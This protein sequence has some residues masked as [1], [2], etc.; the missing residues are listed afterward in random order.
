MIERSS[1]H[2]IVPAP[3]LPELLP[4]NK[5]W[6]TGVGTLLIESVCWLGL[7]NSELSSS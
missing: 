5:E 4:W 3:L 6:N 7:G 2:L 1:L